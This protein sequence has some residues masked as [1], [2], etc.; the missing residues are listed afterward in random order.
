LRNNGPVVEVN[1]VVKVYTTGGVRFEALRGV[2]LRVERGELISILGPSGSG[3]STLLHIMGLI[4]KPTS[5]KVFFEGHDTSKLSEDRLATLRNRR[6][7]FIFQAF[8]L[9]HRLTALENVELPL[10][11]QGMDPKAR[12]SYAMKT[13]DLVGLSS[14]SRNK[15]YEL[16]GGE[17]QKVAIAR[18]LVTSPTIVFGDEL[19][20]NVDSKTTMQIMKLINEINADIGTT[21]VLVTHNP[22]VAAATRR[23][24]TLR[25]GQVERDEQS[26]GT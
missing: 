16:S 12:R 24:I 10:I 22:E 8:N 18:A 11:S 21:F 26:G 1:D 25:D 13:L 19:T 4:D 3:K 9:I 14:K 6:I 7:G 2:R 23:R 17:Q 5:G 15:P 20:G